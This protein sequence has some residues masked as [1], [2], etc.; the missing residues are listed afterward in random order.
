MGRPFEGIRVIDTTHVLAGPFAAYQLAVLGA[1]V[2]KVERLAENIDIFDFALTDAEMREIS[3]LARPG[4]RLVD[5][6]WS[7]KWD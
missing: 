7:P 1:E 2:I 5:W 6:A 3:G 4:A